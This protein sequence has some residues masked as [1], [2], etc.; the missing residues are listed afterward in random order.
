MRCY[1][2]LYGGIGALAEA[3]ADGVTAG[4]AWHREAAVASQPWSWRHC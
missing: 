1:S 4:G 3:A 2:P